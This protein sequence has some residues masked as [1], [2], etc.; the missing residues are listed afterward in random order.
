MDKN[1]KDFDTSFFL[2][3]LIR[4][5]KHLTI[6]GFSAAVFAAF[7]S[8]PIFIT[9]MFDATVTLF[10]TTTA[11][12]SRS[13]LG[14]PGATRDDFLQYGDVVAAERLLQ[15]IGSSTVRNRIGERFNLMEHYEIDEHDRFRNTRFK[16]LYNQNVSA[17]RTAFGAIEITVRDKDPELAANL[18]NEIAA[19]AD[20]VK[21]EIRQERA[22]QAFMVAKNNHDLL[23]EEMDM[24]KDTLQII[25][26]AGVYDILG[27]SG[28]LNRQLAIDLS[29][30]NIRGAQAIK[31]HL[32][33]LGEKGGQYIYLTETIKNLSLNQANAHRIMMETKADF[34]TFMMYH[35]VVDPATVPDK[36]SFPVR[37]L[38]VVLVS[39][40]TGMLAI[41][42]LMIYEQLAA[43]GILKFKA[44][45]S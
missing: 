6:I 24:V 28:M 26:E 8:S 10:P 22:R 39:F 7:F 12:V 45:K 19:L 16:R 15:V 21:N 11:S 3:F 44:G 40:S 36:K 2:I 30:G 38:L 14:G 17:R 18:A 34:E 43:R 1:H 27:Q 37:W 20:T 31:D 29:A 13:V 23:Q 5:W 35:F 32:D 25:M 33:L 41:I 4:W 9:P 42:L